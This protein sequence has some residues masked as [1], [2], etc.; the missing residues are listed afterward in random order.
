MHAILAVAILAGP[1]NETRPAYVTIPVIDYNHMLREV[2]RLRNLLDGKSVPTTQQLIRPNQQ[3]YRTTIAPRSQ[4]FSP[5]TI[6]PPTTSPITTCSGPPGPPGPAGPPGERGPKGEIG[7][8]GKIGVPGERGPK[9]C[10]GER[11]P[12]GNPGTPGETGPEGPQGPPGTI[13]PEEIWF[14]VTLIAPNGDEIKTV[15]VQ[16]QGKLYLNWEPIRAVPQR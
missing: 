16:N 2:T 5:Q 10:P 13:D 1:P 14:D 12:I 7:P 4:R 3:Q 6:R 9:G 11:G 15:R 8:P